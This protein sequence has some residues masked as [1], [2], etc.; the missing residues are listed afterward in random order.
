LQFLES[1]FRRSE[2]FLF[3]GDLNLLRLLLFL[4]PPLESIFTL[5]TLLEQVILESVERRSIQC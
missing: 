5:D 2:P 4:Q 1:L 3:L